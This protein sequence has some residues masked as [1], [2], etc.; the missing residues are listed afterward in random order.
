M[1][2]GRALHRLA[3]FVL[4]PDVCERIVDAQLADFQQ[5]WALADSARKRVVTL[6][7]GYAAFLVVF[8]SCAAGIRDLGS[9]E[10]HA[11]NRVFAIAVGVTAAT[12]MAGAIY[13]ALYG[14]L[15]RPEVLH[16]NPAMRPFWRRARLAL[17][18]GSVNWFLPIAVAFGLMSGIVTGLQRHA[19]RA[20]RRV[21]LL[22]A[23]TLC[24]ALFATTNWIMPLFITSFRFIGDVWTLSEHS[25]RVA[26][27]EHARTNGPGAIRG[28][29]VSYYLRWAFPFAPFALGLFSLSLVN[30]G[31]AV[32]VALGIAGGAAYVYVIRNVTRGTLVW[33][34]RLPTILVAWWPNLMFIALA[35]VIMLVS[36]RA[37]AG[38]NPVS[39]AT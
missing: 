17:L 5:E 28:A 7:R 21:V 3:G 35:L 19:T 11:V 9:D 15:A 16:T 24:V 6:A 14:G 26:V 30:Q 4:P 33:D 37:T 29:Q 38:A 31:R 8:I 36:R 22:V 1:I 27:I 12:F 18:L 25:G 39:C 23:A 32:R 10:R 20:S 2:P 13:A 34:P